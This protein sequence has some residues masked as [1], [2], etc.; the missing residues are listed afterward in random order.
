[1]A[2]K[3]NTPLEAYIAFLDEF[4]RNGAID[5]ALSLLESGEMTVPDLYE[6]VLAPALN[7]IEVPRC[8]EDSMIWRE[9]WMSHIVR[10]TIEA[11]YPFVQK[12]WRQAGPENRGTRVLLACPQEE[13]HEIGIRMGADYF[14]MLGY[15]VAYVGCNTPRDTLV[16]AVTTLKPGVVALGVTNCLNL[17]QLGA[18]VAALKALDPAPAVYLGGSALTHTGKQAA[19]FGADG[20]VSTFASI[21]ALA[22]GRRL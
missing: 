8:R 13:Y 19:D 2:L 17:A 11:A 6:Q 12:A 22:G 20:A 4:D 7:R 1:M 21:K 9:H 10:T 14:T 5:Y 18:I 16:D 15:D 3:Q